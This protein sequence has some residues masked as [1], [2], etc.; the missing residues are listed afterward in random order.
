M[1]LNKCV[2]RNEGSS[3]NNCFFALTGKRLKGDSS[4]NALAIKAFKLK[5]GNNNWTVPTSGAGYAWH[6]SEDKKTMILVPRE[7]HSVPYG[8]IRHTGGCSLINKAC[9]MP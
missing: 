1:L 3:E 6:H 5:T 7:V 4:D 8:G 9:K 2:R